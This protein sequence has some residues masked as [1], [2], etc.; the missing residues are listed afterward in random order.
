M[1]GVPTLT[2]RSWD[3]QT[4]QPFSPRDRLLLVCR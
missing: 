3:Y 1:H 4:P 2:W